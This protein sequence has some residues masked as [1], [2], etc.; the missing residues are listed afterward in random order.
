M[1]KT[2][3]VTSPCWPQPHSSLWVS[4]GTRLAQEATFGFSLNCPF[5]RHAA[6][7]PSAPPP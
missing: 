2:W 4:S 5:Q 7:S 6:V 1:V 3:R